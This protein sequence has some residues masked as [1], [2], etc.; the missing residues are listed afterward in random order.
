MAD[1]PLD[2]NSLSFTKL[3]AK[4]LKASRDLLAGIK[5]V[6]KRTFPT[7]E[8]FEFDNELRKRTTS[9]Y[10]AYDEHAKLYGYVVYV[11][12]K[13]ATRIHKV[14]VIEQYRQKGVGKWMMSLVLREL[15]KGAAGKVD[16]WV[17][18]AR[19]PARRLYHACG[20]QEKEVVQNYYSAGRDGVRMEI[21]C[22]P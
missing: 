22:E 11:R 20:F 18:T 9:L 17:D 6:E 13:L 1:L 16:L 12:S 14:C 8:A 7:K 15:Q 19:E 10:C 4:S 21:Y 2:L 5:N 3:P